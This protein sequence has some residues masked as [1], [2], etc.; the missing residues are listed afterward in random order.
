[1]SCHTGI[2][3]TV[4]C[5]GSSK[6]NHKI[7]II[8]LIIIKYSF[9]NY[10]L[11]AFS[12]GFCTFKGVHK[13]IIYDR[14]MQE[15]VQRYIKIC[16]A[17]ISNLKIVPKSSLSRLCDISAMVHYIHEDIHVALTRCQ[18]SHFDHCGQI[19]NVKFS[20]LSFTRS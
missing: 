20:R 8:I 7:M 18:F 6:K 10:N 17:Q 14:Y 19:R 2:R 5:Y 4:I 9:P 15:N 12:P 16:A 11:S 3:K 1:M 13:I